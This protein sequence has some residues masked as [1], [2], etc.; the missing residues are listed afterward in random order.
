MSDGL[1]LT[2][3]VLAAS[4][5]GL[6]AWRRWHHRSYWLCLGYPLT[7]VRVRL[8]WRKVALGCGLTK[9]RQRFWFT[10]VPGL[11]SSTGLV[12]VKRRL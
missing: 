8:T 11:I 2:L 5:A 9:K 1:L 4:A 7:A 12:R 10:T 3:G 6:W